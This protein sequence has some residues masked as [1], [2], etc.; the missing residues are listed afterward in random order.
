METLRGDVQQLRKGLDITKN[1]REKQPDNYALHVSFSKKIKLLLTVSRFFKKI[2][3]IFLSV[4][5]GL[6]LDLLDY[7]KCKPL[8]ILNKPYHKLRHKQ[9]FPRYHT[10]AMKSQ[11]ALSVQSNF[12]FIA[13]VR[14]ADYDN[15][16]ITRHILFV[17]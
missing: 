5:I 8:P 3:N 11:R 13:P 1:E 9:H 10:I 16:M 4:P 14:F 15:L 17:T 7:K 2:G 12:V 6:I